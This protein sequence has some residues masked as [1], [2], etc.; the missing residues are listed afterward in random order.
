MKKTNKNLKIIGVIA[1]P[2][3]DTDDTKFV[4]IN[5]NI[6]KSIIKKKCIPLIINPINIFN[7]DK[8]NTKKKLSDIEKE[9]YKNI[10]DNCDGLIIS[11]GTKWYN[12]DVF[13]V[14]YAIKKDIPILGICMGMQ[15]LASI[16]LG[17]NNLEININKHYYKNKRY[18]HNIFIMDNT[19]LKS[20]INKDIIKVNSRHNYHIKKAD[21][22][23]ISAYSSDGY[24]EAIEMPNKKCIIGLQ[25]HPEDMLNYDINAN[26][27]YNYFI[28]KL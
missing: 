3:K 25:W 21:N 9:Y 15:L 8:D 17:E 23:I 24:I 22:F 27:I 7:F 2:Y 28:S 19:I 20:I 13:I 26:K 14:K 10:I 18:A 12:Y 11:G 16:D 1:R 6:R 4:S 5:E